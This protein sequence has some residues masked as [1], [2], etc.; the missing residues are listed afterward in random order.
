MYVL[1]HVLENIELDRKLLTRIASHEGWEN[2]LSST[3]KKSNSKITVGIAIV[4]VLIIAIIAGVYLYSPQQQA[5][6]TTATETAAAETTTS[7]AAAYKIA[8]ITTAPAEEAWSG[9]IHTALEH[10]VDVYG[11]N[12]ITYKWTENVQYADVPRIMREYGSN[13]FNMVFADAFGADDTARAAAKDFPNTYFVLGTDNHDFGDNVAVFD[14]W[15]HEPAYISGMIAGNITKSNI[16]G[17]VGGVADPEVNRLINAFRDGARAVN[18]KVKVLVTFMG[19]WFNPPK[20]KEAALAEI[21]QGAD[22][23]YSER[24]GGIEAAEEKGIPV[25]GSLQDQWQLAPDVVI[26]GPVW[27]MWPTV[28]HEIDLMMQNKWVPED[29]RFYSMM[30]KGGA[31]LAPWHDW[32][33]RLKPDIVARMQQAGVI[34]MVDN[35]TSQIMSGWFTVPMD[36]SEPVSG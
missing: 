31:S 1:Y 7:A 30:G 32:E 15:I 36:E 27:D 9:V 26:T 6:V 11:A 8:F 29:L 24:Q 23:I 35:I 20:A 17:V 4:L 18:P 16:I 12:V 14:D 3:E 13:G 10:A 21:S 33:T 2:T 22:V 34:Q 28:K 5:A 19:E 25:F